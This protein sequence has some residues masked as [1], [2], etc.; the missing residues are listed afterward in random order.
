MKNKTNIIFIILVVIITLNFW[1]SFFIYYLYSSE[2]TKQDEKI[3]N[4]ESRIWILNELIIENNKSD[5]KIN[6]IEQFKINNDPINN[7]DDFFDESEEVFNRWFDININ[8]FVHWNKNSYSRSNLY[9]INWKVF[10][11]N[12]DVNWDQVKWTISTENKALITKIEQLIIDLNYYTQID[13]NTLNFS[14]TTDYIDKILDILNN[15]SSL[16]LD[17][18]DLDNLQENE[19]GGY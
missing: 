1:Y 9:I 14:W 18:I 3:E 6:K 19:K 13:W 16:N 7:L 8:P 12:I 5:E 10:S 17:K 11:Y 2:K 4:L 15:A